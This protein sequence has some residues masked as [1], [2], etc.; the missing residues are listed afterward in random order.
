M[1]TRVA[2]VAL[3][4]LGAVLIVHGRDG[5][6]RG[7]SLSRPIG[8]TTL[9]R[10]ARTPAASPDSSLPVRCVTTLTKPCL[11]RSAKVRPAVSGNSTNLESFT[12]DAAVPRLGIPMGHAHP[13]LSSSRRQ[14]FARRSRPVRL[15]I[16]TL[17]ISVSVSELGLSANGN[18][19]VPTNFYVPGWYKFGPSPGQQG[20]AV[21]LGHVDSYKGPA[22]FFRLSQLRPREQ[23]AVVLANGNVERFH[24]IGVRMYSKGRF[25]DRLVYGRRW[26][27]ALQLVTCGGVFDH[28][29]GHYESNIVVFTARNKS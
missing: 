14:R 12:T 1:F 23:V 2:S 18:V 19:D 26:Y 4:V 8:V 9:K 25:P 21:I 10:P 13:L 22:I 11:D 29:T 17:G 20:S 16:P 3:I 27:S 5:V 6:D 15:S 28:Q 24:V 7:P